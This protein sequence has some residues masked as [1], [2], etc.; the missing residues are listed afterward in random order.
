MKPYA[1]PNHH[2]PNLCKA[3]VHD[4]NY[5]LL[6]EMATHSNILAWRIPWTE[7]PGRLQSMGLK[8]QTQLKRLS[9]IISH[10][11]LPPQGAGQA[12]MSLGTR[13]VFVSCLVPEGCE[14]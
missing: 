10:V 3:K 8:S 2:A 7:E 9:I 12:Q 14:A 5:V 13:R 1:L 11:C 4:S 6:E